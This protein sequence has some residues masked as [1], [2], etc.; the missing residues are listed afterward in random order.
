MDFRQRKSWGKTKFVHIEKLLND[1][2]VS[3]DNTLTFRFAV[4]PP[5]ILQKLVYQRK[6][7]ASLQRQLKNIRR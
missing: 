5:S 1:Q 2:Y 4:R 6:L 7:I 3:D